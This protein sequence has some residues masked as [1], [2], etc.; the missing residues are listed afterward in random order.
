[1]NRQASQSGT[2]GDSENSAA[3]KGSWLTRRRLRYKIHPTVAFADVKST[4]KTGDIILF[5]KTTRNGL[6]DVLELDIL[7]PLFFDRNEFRH[8]GIIVRRGAD[9]FVMECTEERHSGYSHAVYPTGGKGIREVPLVPLLEEY[10]RDNGQAHFGIRSIAS[11]IPLESLLEIVREVGPVSYLKGHRSVTI[12]L[13]QYI[14]PRPVLRKVVDRN[15]HLMMCSEFV[16][17][18]L[19]RHGALR[20]FPSKLFA[21]YIIEN[22]ALFSSHEVVPFSEIVRFTY[23]DTPQLR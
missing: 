9:L 10:T 2:P 15:A 19:S 7:A 5:H 11:E 22:P 21:P 16:H 4:L 14:L 17:R 12:F 6:L 8:S 18:V 23:P 3:S 1:M 13:S 20:S